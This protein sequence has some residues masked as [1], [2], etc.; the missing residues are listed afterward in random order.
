MEE[1]NKIQWKFCKN[2]LY[3]NEV[4]FTNDGIIHYHNIYVWNE[5]NL[6]EVFESSSHDKFCVNIWR[7]Q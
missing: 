6:N 1:N 3:T 4:T 7:G 2:V 5:E